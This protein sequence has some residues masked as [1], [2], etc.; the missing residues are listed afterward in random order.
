MLKRLI[1]RLARLKAKIVFRALQIRI[2]AIR[3]FDAFNI[4]SILGLCVYI[5]VIPMIMELLE[6][7]STS[8]SGTAGALLSAIIGLIP[9][10][11]VVKVLD[12]INL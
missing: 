1:S 3:V 12:K 10:L 4:K 9:L 7:L 2:I 6:S 8:L 5:A 11:L